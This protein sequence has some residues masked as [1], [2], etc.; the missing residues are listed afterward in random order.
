MELEHEV[1]TNTA[2]LRA[3]HKIVGA[4]CITIICCTI[5]IAAIVGW[6]GSRIDLSV[7]LMRQIDTDRVVRAKTITIVREAR[8]DASRIRAKLT[9]DAVGN[10]ES[11]ER[12]DKLDAMLGDVVQIN[13]G[14]P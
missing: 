8:L 5:T 7:N 9:L 3:V 14:G 12:L 6:Y 11:I 13:G 10:A 4:L 1:Q 2:V